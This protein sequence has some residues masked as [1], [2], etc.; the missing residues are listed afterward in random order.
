MCNVLPVYAITPLF[1]F[2][3]NSPVFLIYSISAH[4]PPSQDVSFSH[5]QSSDHQTGNDSGEA[6]LDLASSTGGLGET[7]RAS[8]A[9]RRLG[10]SSGSGDSAVAASLSARAGRVHRDEGRARGAGRLVG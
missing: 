6:E 3:I 1:H 5:L 8:R 10:S 9:A 7:A 2:S 4:Y